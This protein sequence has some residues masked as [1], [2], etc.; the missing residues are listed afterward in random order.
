MATRPKPPAEFPTR[1]RCFITELLNRE[2][3]PS[4]SV[5]RARV[6]PGVTTE[7]HA[8]DVEEWY[9]V[10]SGAGIVR[11]GGAPPR[12]LRPGDHVRIPPRC[13]QQVTNAGPADLLFFCVCTPRFT[14]AAYRALE[15]EDE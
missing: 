8:L 1:E 14:P 15:R 4:V 9:V 12:T 3:I 2:S 11:I 10:E 6:E 7:L 5:A 13:S